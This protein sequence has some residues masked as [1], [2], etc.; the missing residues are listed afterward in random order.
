MPHN[1]AFHQGLHCLLRD[2]SLFKCQG[3]HVKIGTIKSLKFFLA[4]FARSFFF[5]FFY[6]F[7]FINQPHIYL[8][9]QATKFLNFYIF[10]SA[11]GIVLLCN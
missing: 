7:F 3:G 9:R 2:R 11:K 5:F 10:A 1:V 8:V 6:L 4:C